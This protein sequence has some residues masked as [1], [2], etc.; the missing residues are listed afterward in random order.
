MGN[1]GAT[2]QESVRNNLWKDLGF[3]WVI[4]ECGDLLCIG[5]CLLSEGRDKFMVM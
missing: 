4:R 5:C 2:Q 1:L 3:G